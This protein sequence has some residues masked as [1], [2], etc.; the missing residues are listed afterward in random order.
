M[1]NWANRTKTAANATNISE[2]NLVDVGGSSKFENVSKYYGYTTPKE[3]RTNSAQLQEGDTF[4]GTYEGFFIGKQ[5]GTKTYKVRTNEEG[6][7]GITGSGLLNKLMESV[8]PGATV[9][10]VY[11]GQETMEKGK[12]AGRKAHAFTVRASKDQVTQG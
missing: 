12:Y 10:I 11:R 7:I 9:K 5:Y 4:L 8:N 6:L 1:S 2:A 3:G